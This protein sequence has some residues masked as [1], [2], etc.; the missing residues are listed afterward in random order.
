MIKNK[1]NK[2]IYVLLVILVF[3]TYLFIIEKKSHLINYKYTQEIIIETKTTQNGI[4]KI[5]Y[6]TG[7]GFNDKESFTFLMQ[8]N[9]DFKKIS[10]KLPD[11]P[12]LSIRIDP[13][14]FPLGKKN[15]IWI[16][17]IHLKTIDDIYEWSPK[18]I[19]RD[20]KPNKHIISFEV[21]DNVL[22]VNTDGNDP[23]F[24]SKFLVYSKIANLTLPQESYPGA[25]W[26]DFV[27]IYDSDVSIEGWGFIE[28]IDSKTSKIYIILMSDKSKFIYDAFSRTRQ[29]LT[30]HFNSKVDLDQSGFLVVIPKADLPD[31]EYKIGVYI[32]ND[33]KKTL[34]W[35]NKT[36]KEHFL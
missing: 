24:I 20:F 10:L 7:K 26:V 6:N 22:K 3:V 1:N 16:K 8:V 31:E 33:G 5:Y 21:E 18:D 12:I 25:A 23:F 13:I 30:N 27:N 4:F 35:T 19:I 32:I 36:L 9:N 11:I 14:D 2:Y 34:V 15:S 28:G 17:S 29:G